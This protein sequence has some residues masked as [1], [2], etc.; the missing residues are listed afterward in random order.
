[1]KWKRW[2]FLGGVAP[3]ALLG[4]GTGEEAFEVVRHFDAKPVGQGGPT[5]PTLEAV[6]SA[7]AGGDAAESGVPT[8]FVYTQSSAELQAAARVWASGG[9]EVSELA[10]CK[11]APG[12]AVVCADQA[13]ALV[14]A[15]VLDGLFH[16]AGCSD[17]VI[18]DDPGAVARRC[19]DPDVYACAASV[20]PANAEEFVHCYD[21]RGVS[22]LSGWQRA[23][24]AEG[25][26]TVRDLDVLK[27]R[28]ETETCVRKVAGWSMPESAVTTAFLK[29]DV[30]NG[31]VC[32]NVNET[33]F[34]WRYQGSTFV[35]SVD[36]QAAAHA[37]DEARFELTVSPYDGYSLDTRWFPQLLCARY[38]AH[39]PTWSM[40]VA[41][42]DAS[43]EIAV[44][45]GATRPRAAELGED[46]L[47]VLM[48]EQPQCQLVEVGAGADW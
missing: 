26:C 41:W 10:W 18:G 21:A 7:P 27:S 9:C 13:G 25:A 19:S 16:A 45:Q 30:L 15:H 44:G 32:S 35:Y 43:V 1:M 12:G 2:I 3:A 29:P 11:D 46:M 36:V 33:R 6:E 14:A 5:L 28:F 48:G 47:E 38:A 17:R 24:V 40:E 23:L 4:C 8:G 42:H 20:D 37:A 22:V 39:G 31:E 34:E